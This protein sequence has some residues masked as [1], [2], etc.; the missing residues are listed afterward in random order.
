MQN[1]KEINISTKEQQESISFMN[2]LKDKT[3]TEILN[4]LLSK[5]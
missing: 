2:L 3:E 1:T 5:K 4:I